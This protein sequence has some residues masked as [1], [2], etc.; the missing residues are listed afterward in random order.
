MKYRVGD[1][2]TIRSW[3]SL[4]RRNIYFNPNFREICENKVKIVLK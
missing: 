1:V 4:K 2:V 3:E